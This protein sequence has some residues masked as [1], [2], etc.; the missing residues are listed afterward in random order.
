[1]WPIPEIQKIMTETWFSAAKRADY[2]AVRSLGSKYFRAHNDDDGGNT[3]LLYAISSNNM[4]LISYLAP[5]E[6]REVNAFG[7]SA[8]MFAAYYGNCDAV[9]IFLD[10]EK[11]MR[12]QE[13][14]KGIP[15]GA[16]ALL[17]AATRGHANCVTLLYPVERSASGWNDLFLAAFTH[18][19][20]LVARHDSLVSTRDVLGRTAMMYLVMFPRHS[21]L[22]SLEKCIVHLAQAQQGAIDACTKTALMYAVENNNIDAVQLLLQL[23]TLEIRK[24][25]EA[26]DEYTALMIAASRGYNDI[27]AQLLPK[28]AGIVTSNGV[29]ALMLAVR[30]NQIEAARLLKDVESEFQ[31][32]GPFD[33]FSP[34]AT[35]LSIARYYQRQ[36]LLSLLGAGSL[37]IT[38][39][40]EKSLYPGPEG[41]AK[42]PKSMTMSSVLTSQRKDHMHLSINEDSRV[43]ATISP[44]FKSNLNA[45]RPTP[46][47]HSTGELQD[48]DQLVLTDTQTVAI[49][50]NTE[51]LER[52][53]ETNQDL[54][55][56]VFTMQR[57]M[58]LES[59][60]QQNTIDKLDIE[61]NLTRQRQSE[62][63]SKL[64][65]AEEKITMYKDYSQ[66]AYKHN[67]SLSKKF[68]EL[69][70]SYDSVTQEN[71]QLSTS[72]AS[73]RSEK[74][75]L[76]AVH[77]DLAL[78]FD[79]LQRQIKVDKSTTDSQITKYSTEILALQKDLSEMKQTLTTAQDAASTNE[80][81]ARLATEELAQLRPRYQD[82]TEKMSDLKV[83]YEETDVHNKAVQQENNL[84]KEELDKA[85]TSLALLQ[86]ESINIKE[87]LTELEASNA[88]L[89]TTVTDLNKEKISQALACEKLSGQNAGM[90]DQ[91]QELQHSLQRATNETE[92]LSA[93]LAEHVLESQNLRATISQLQ[94]D[95]TSLTDEKDVLQTQLCADQER[96][97]ITKSDLSAA[98]QEVAMLKETL[99]KVS[100]DY[101]RLEEDSQR[102]QMQ[103]IEQQE[104]TQRAESIKT[105]LEVRL[106]TIEEQ[107]LESQ[108]GVNVGQQDLAAL[109]TELQIMTKKYECLEIHAAELETTTAEL[110]REKATLIA[111]TKD[112]TE[113]KESL[114]GQLNSLSFQAEQLQNDKSALERQVSDLLVII[115]QEQETQASLKKQV[116]D[117][118][119]K[120]AE[121]DEEIIR[122][123]DKL[124]KTM[125]EMSV[126]TSKLATSE[127]SIAKAE[128]KFAS[129][130]KERNSLFKELS[131]VTKELTDLKL[132]NES[133]EKDAQ[134]TQ[135]KLKEVN[136]SKKSLE[137]SSSNSSKK[138]ANLSSAKA[139][140][141]K[142]LSNATAHISDL[143]SQLTTLEKKDSESKQALLAKDKSIDEANRSVSQLKRQLK[144]T[145]ADNETVQKNIIA[146]TKELTSLQLLK[147]QSDTTILKLTKAVADEKEENQSLNEQL[148][149][150]N[151]QISTL[152][153]AQDAIELARIS[154]T[155]RVE[156]LLSENKGLGE[157]IADLK[158]IITNTQNA[159]QEV[160]EERNSAVDRIKQADNKIAAYVSDQQTSK[161]SMDQLRAD[162]STMEGANKR[163]QK[164]IATRIEL[165]EELERK[166]DQLSK[167]NSE[168]IGCQAT[169]EEQLHSKDAALNDGQLARENLERELMLA[170]KN[171]HD[172]REEYAELQQMLAS[173]RVD[174]ENMSESKLSADA[175]LQKA[176]DKCSAFQA[177]VTLGQKSIE[178]MA[179]H[180]KVLEGEISKLK[181]K[182]AALLGSLSETEASKESVERDLKVAKGKITETEERIS[183]IEQEKARI[184][185]GLQ[186]I[187][188]E[189]DGIERRLKE[190]SQ[191]VEEQHAE[192]EAL[193][194]ALAASNELNTDLTSNSESSIKTLQQ[195]SRQLAES[196]GEVAGLK[197]GAELTACRLAE[198]EA[199]C[200]EQ[201]RTISTKNSTTTELQMERDLL[202]KRLAACTASSKELEDIL[203]TMQK[204]YSDQSKKLME[205]E[206][207]NVVLQRNISSSA[208]ATED[209]TSAL[210]AANQTVA[211]TGKKIL[212]LEE[213]REIL[214]RS[215]AHINK[216]NTTL[217]TEKE[218]LAKNLIEA[219][220]AA[221][222]AE[223]EQNSLAKETISLRDLVTELEGKLS[224]SATTISAK[225]AM[226][227]DLE[228]QVDTMT[229]EHSDLMA[230]K[231]ELETERDSLQAR[232]KAYT[233]TIAELEK[234]KRDVDQLL[235][236][237][238]NK[239][240]EQEMAF[241]TAERTLK[242][243][244]EKLKST[245]QEKDTA[246][247]VQADLKNELTTLSETAKMLEDTVNSLTK[248]ISERD[249]DNESLRTVANG[250]RT[251]EEKAQ[252][253]IERQ[254]NIIL[255]YQQ[256]VSQAG[257][258]RLALI[259]QIDQEKKKAMDIMASKQ[260]L[261]DDLQAFRKR[262]SEL[263]TEYDSLKKALAS[264]NTT[265]EKLTLQCSSLTAELST[266]KLQYN[267]TRLE[268][269]SA[270][271][272]VETTKRGSVSLQGEIDKLSRDLQQANEVNAQLRVEQGILQQSLDNTNASLNTLV[273][274]GETLSKAT[275]DSN[276]KLHDYMSE[277]TLKNNE[278]DSL[279]RSL[280]RKEADIEELCVRMN[281]KIE[282]VRQLHSDK[283]QAEA[284]IC[285]LLSENSD[286]KMTINGLTSTLDS[287]KQ[288]VKDLEGELASAH[289]ELKNTS[290]EVRRLELELK[291]V[292]ENN[293]DSHNRLET[294]NQQIASYEKQ[295]SSITEEKEGLSKLISQLK[296]T[297]NELTLA[298]QE[299][300]AG[301][302][303]EKV[304]S[305]KLS[306]ENDDLSKRLESGKA[307]YEELS[308]EHKSLLE[309]YHTLNSMKELANTE[310]DALRSMTN[311]SKAD[312][313]KFSAD[314]EQFR[315]HTLQDRATIAKLQ[316]D[317]EKLESKNKFLADEKAQCTKIIKSLNKDIVDLKLQLHS[318]DQSKESAARRLS[319][320]GS[321]KE[322]LI[323][324][325]NDLRKQIC[326]Q[327]RLI[328][329]LQ[330]QSK[331]AERLK[332]DLAHMNATMGE[333]ADMY[334][335]TIN[336]Y[337]DA[338]RHHNDIAKFMPKYNTYMSDSGLMTDARLRHFLE[339]NKALLDEKA[340]TE[341][342]FKRLSEYVNYIKA[343]LVNTDMKYLAWIQHKT[344][345]FNK[346]VANTQPTSRP[347]FMTQTIDEQARRLSTAL[348][349]TD[350]SASDEINIER[351]SLD[352]ASL[353][354][355]LQAREIKY[356]ATRTA[357]Y[358]H[359][360]SRP[361]SQNN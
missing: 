161:A 90:E 336:K 236:T 358:D 10:D 36:E 153:N 69:K 28:E 120:S 213:R 26:K 71:A 328:Q 125:E 15:T 225:S 16:T 215:L 317:L 196:Q 73:L 276:K 296:L 49:L 237:A 93:R 67:E 346:S 191:L 151:K 103:L 169:L 1:M 260:E 76:E 238:N 349:P 248:Q 355:Q 293:K 95:L 313:D 187:T 79:E 197:R 267:S 174:I 189:K 254:R 259:Q 60:E 173:K 55:T 269:E 212:E 257:L 202:F 222:A 253:E 185:K 228:N 299:V 245:K 65:L 150:A 298:K 205:L 309:K 159:L 165:Y 303:A 140:L 41:L 256:Q 58:Q 324:E 310:L 341:R 304:V 100:S 91:V 52:L 152:R 301:L 126:L 63:E 314:Y 42:S 287:Q 320:L 250:H 350:F 223:A 145:K 101:R 186:V 278:V 302:A 148:N 193:K 3:A 226:I 144:D 211:E 27:V 47:H 351:A 357:Q 135:Q 279:K 290:S 106:V 74:A 235:A 221:A 249:R 200:D 338:M 264:N 5:H 262:Y 110:T 347:D 130:S 335:V 210:T 339:N 286:L 121:L 234:S 319:V 164:D 330:K 46:T 158:G 177:E 92:S 98:R 18:N 216:R 17:I 217:E 282:E 255:D 9:K 294:L 147:E 273:T 188:G 353:A 25:M 343:E 192:L 66:Q 268:L 176:M 184:F 229:R 261:Q 297:I 109:R 321:D 6:V 201:A 214:E 274:Q 232:T 194:K 44:I 306:S 327:E 84:L 312:L 285:V 180:I 244:K 308:T 233:E 277:L 160:T 231:L 86:E 87:R 199:L 138:I 43:A 112:T 32:S 218:Q 265:M 295:V 342:K 162:L 163:L 325:V 300:S 127:E 203:S 155:D 111:K 307:A 37:Q 53:K 242:S 115:S 99:D 337:A 118:S 142:Q 315:A 166:N 64:K 21:T 19:A 340:L 34:A 263:D 168:L 33:V 11:G 227:L 131:T 133:L 241:Q 31:T 7:W 88:T 356:D 198:L 275:A 220:R 45:S 38:T 283:E 179:Q 35:A 2:G 178:S 50:S 167:Q 266:L 352:R 149:E 170:N 291:T 280:A 141:E 239:L 270:Q 123:R 23:T 40:E 81:N 75:S 54:A 195:L 146:L 172:L 333:F 323:T 204:E 77:K 56:R 292:N 354:K 258:E 30:Y 128:A 61:L 190:K 281:S 224:V 243:L 326:D 70:D 206:A 124:N 39:T 122:L 157:L 14:Y 143:E 331:E 22:A 348:E 113:E 345:V 240:L 119:R 108:R 318:L 102:T 20:A 334:A 251:N 207:D 289:G 182:N 156:E 129:L 271:M 51:A 246:L 361:S 175:A 316:S 97:T 83:L 359:Y 137:Q 311:M 59:I 94:K 13:E 8:L 332:E 29:T 78:L 114:V 230:L 96:L 344:A 104:L 183:E 154:A 105:T 24:Q 136:L 132:T 305:L 82:L 171:C 107:L 322:A 208:K 62:L 12:T 272:L 219:N 181:E 134:S 57:S 89:H 48:N 252:E 80:Q 72:L 117:A 116:G 288:S 68:A 284:R 247:S 4:Q 360:P 139:A 85:T 209:L 329:E